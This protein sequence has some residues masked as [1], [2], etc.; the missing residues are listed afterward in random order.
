MP[1][2]KEHIQKSIEKTGKDYGGV[3]EWID[4]PQWKN[5]RHS[6]MKM[7]EYGRMFNDSHGEEGQAE[8]LAHLHD[9]LLGKFGHLA[10]DVEKAG[11]EIVKGHERTVRETLPAEA[12]DAWVQS[13]GPDLGMR[14]QSLSQEVERIVKETLTYFGVGKGE[15]SPLYAGQAE[16]LELLRSAGVAE[17]D[18]RHCLAVARKALEIARRTGGQ[19][20]LELIARGA[21]FHDLGKAKTHAIEHG[22]IGAELGRKL[23]LP[24][25]VTDIM[26][27]HIRGGLTEAEAVELGLPVKDYTL[28]RL[29]ERI[30]IYADRLVDIISDKVVKEEPEAETRF[31]E[32]LAGDVKYGKNDKTL[33]RYLGYHRE[34][35]GL[36][37]PK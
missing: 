19:L 32:I 24:P 37:A 1:P 13:A 33:Q 14:L 8:Y 34:I 36:T 17:E 3:H 29:E 15:Q 25:A 30:I 18:I 2:T 20:D 4:D 12:A 26:E 16:D 10:E 7:I 31:E 23:G 9:D 35:Q 21:L 6:V 28:S 5:Q 11:R 22:R 27:K